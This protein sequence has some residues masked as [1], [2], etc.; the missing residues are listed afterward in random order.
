MA[1]NVDDQ[2]VEETLEHAFKIGNK[3]MAEQLLPCIKTVDVRTTSK[4]LWYSATDKTRTVAKVSLLH[5]AARWGWIDIA[6][7]LVTKHR[8]SAQWRDD[9]GSI[10]LHYAAHYGHLMIAKY[11]ISELHCDPAEKNQF[12]DT[13]LH[14]ACENGHI[15]IVRFFIFEAHCN[16]SECVDI[17]GKTPLHNACMNNSGHLNIVRYLIGEV[18]CD[19][20]SENEN[21]MTPLHIA[22]RN[23]HLNIVQYLITEAH[24]NPSCEN[25]NGMT[26]IHNA[27]SNGRLNIVQ[28]LI[29]EGHCNPSQ[30]SNSGRTPLHY[31]CSNG[32][33]NITQYLIS[34]THCNPSCKSNRGNTP[35]HIAFH[36]GHF[37]LVQYLISE[38]HCNPSDVNNIGSTPLHYACDKN[39]AK[40]VQYLLSTG[41]VNPLTENKH[42]QTPLSLATG[43]YET[44]KV[45]QPCIDYS[46][47]YPVHT[48]TK[49]ILTGDSSA[50]KTTMAQLI[51]RLAD[52]ASSTLPA[53]VVSVT[54]VQ[55]F[56]A[57][58]VPYHV[59]SDELGNFIIYDFAGQ[60]E[61]Y[62]SHA[63][64]L[65]QVIRKSAAM[66]LCIIDMS[67]SNENMCQ[68][69]KY[70]LTFIN[71]AC[72]AVDDTSHV[73]IIGSHADQVMLEEMEEKILQLQR[74]AVRRVNHLKYAGYIAMDCRHANTEMTHEFISILTTSR[75]TII[76]HQ[77]AISFYCHV[78]YA[79][80]RTKLEMVGC[81]LHDLISVIAMENDP[82]LPKDPL[83]LVEL[84]TFLSDK[85]LILFIQHSQSRNW[86]VVK[87]E[88]L[89]KEINGTLFAPHYFKEHHDLAS[90][91][92]IVPTSNLH[93]VFPQHNLEMLV[94][95]LVSLD[96]CL[97]VDSSVL[98]Y[99]NLQTIPSHSTTNLLFFP[100]LIQSGRPDSLTQHIALQFGWC[101][102][103][104]D[105][106]Q[107]FG[108]RFLHLLLLSVAYQFPLA[109]RRNVPFSVRGLQRRCSVWKNGISWR[110]SD[111]ITVVV[112]LI[113]KN[114]WVL[115][116]MSCSE[117]RPVEHA[118]LRSELISLV[119]NLH[120]KHC[121]NLEV[122]ECLVSPSMVQQYP[123]DDLPDTELFDIQDVAM[124]ILLQK[125]LI[126]SQS[127]ECMGHLPTHSL[128][129]EPYHLICP[130]LVCQ[131]FDSS[132]ANEPVPA[133]L[134]QAVQKYINQPCKSKV[135]QE[136]RECMDRLSIFAGRNPLVNVA[137][138]ILI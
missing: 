52:E 138:I 81:T 98:Q 97:P 61:Y 110:N 125:P 39:H 92:G 117:D 30:E 63:A 118:K 23:G 109:T 102:G 29:S 114:R 31:A 77:P 10:P 57:G 37:N 13:P 18:H 108:S 68:S 44:M 70:W 85:G 4:S 7:L 105:S 101:L 47:D 134:L 116:A 137:S 17:Q 71:N 75:K 3:R 62:S 123:F 12:H 53:P 16:P 73:A 129:F 8:S 133:H 9:E 72:S 65:E 93:K 25:K 124:S 111:N 107:F 106:S 54:D 66:F 5:L 82:S 90:N 38:A 26:P 11:F 40:I 45:L 28:Y 99:T 126:P 103:C 104:L 94:G 112:E 100:G 41:R 95:F 24:C 67:R 132:L 60:Q 136:L 113:D 64:I 86:V 43:K 119:H 96:F 91:T 35:L 121:P 20:S 128:P 135:Y 46:R 55:S 79:F 120:H 14:L 50:G 48:Y 34:E 78:L 76:A 27:C 87:T 80:L 22:S 115:V 36:S 56:T 33:L 130:H 74:I 58:I 83:I 131:L 69:L 122:C 1:N 32:H 19:P 89:L 88:I 59:E 49:L 42:G 2:R 127:E 51:V 21:G 6:I 15:D 84:L